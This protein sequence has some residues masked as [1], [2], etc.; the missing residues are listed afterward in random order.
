[1]L[2]AGVGFRLGRPEEMGESVG[3]DGEDTRPGGGFDKEDGNL[4]C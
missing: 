1:M 3:R 4:A 2:G